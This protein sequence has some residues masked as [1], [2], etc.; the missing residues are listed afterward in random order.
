MSW[1]VAAEAPMV[2]NFCGF[3]MVIKVLRVPRGKFAVT[4]PEA[5]SVK[6]RWV[7]G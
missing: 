1:N 7:E 3:G 6:G 4:D 2:K 5:P